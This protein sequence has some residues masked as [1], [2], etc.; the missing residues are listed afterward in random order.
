MSNEKKNKRQLFAGR[1]AGDEILRYVG[2][3]FINHE[4]IGDPG[5]PLNNQDLMERPFFFVAQ[6]QSSE[7]TWF[8]K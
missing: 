8:E 6:N 5:S 4:I 7:F 1:N 2:D 3:F